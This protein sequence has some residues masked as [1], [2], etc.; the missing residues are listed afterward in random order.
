MTKESTREPVPSR[1]LRCQHNLILPPTPTLLSIRIPPVFLQRQHP[2]PA[3]IP[4]A[5]LEFPLCESKDANLITPV[6]CLTN[7]LAQKVPSFRGSVGSDAIPVDFHTLDSQLCLCP[8]Q[9]GALLGAVGEAA[10]LYHDG[11]CPTGKAGVGGLLFF[12]TMSFNTEATSSLDRSLSFH[13]FF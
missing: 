11:V 2:T 4:T 3:Q 7:P 8:I 13:F 10:H 12:Q 6:S 1:S 5:S 9:R